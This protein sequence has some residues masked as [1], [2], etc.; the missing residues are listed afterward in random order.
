MGTLYNKSTRE[1]TG[2]EKHLNFILIRREQNNS[3][4]GN[5]SSW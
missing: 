5:N 2:N 3:K 1:R 4:A